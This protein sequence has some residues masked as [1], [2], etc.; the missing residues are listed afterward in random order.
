[1]TLTKQQ[2]KEKIIYLC[3]KLNIAEPKVWNY[4]NV[5]YTANLINKE[6]K[7]REKICP[8]CFGGIFLSSIICPCEV[9]RMN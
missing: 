9:K 6:L 3:K 5:S 8:Y 7:K 2:A 4:Q 1:M